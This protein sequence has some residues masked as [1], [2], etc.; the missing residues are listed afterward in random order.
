MIFLLI[1]L[2]A[3]PPETL[4][5]SIGNGGVYSAVPIEDVTGDGIPDIIAALY[6]S[7]PEPTLYAI[8][9]ADGAVIWNS[10]DCKGIW[11]NEALS[12]VPDCNNDGYQDVFL[13][14]P[15]GY[16]PPGRCAILVNGFTGEVI[17]FWSAYQHAP[18]SAGWGYTTDFMNDF[19]GDEITELLAGFGTSSPDNKGC[20]ACLDGATGDTLWTAV[21]D[22]AVQDLKSLVDIT[23]DDIEEIAVG[24]GG[25]GYTEHTLAVLD[26]FSGDFLW[27]IDAGGDVHSVSLCNREDTTPY[28]LASTWDTTVG[29]YHIGHAEAVWTQS[30]S[31]GWWL[32]VKG[33]PDLTE[34]GIGEVLLAADDIGM[35]CYSGV[36][37]SILWTYPSG[38]NTWS[39]DWLEEVILSGVSEVCAV[40]GA[41]NGYRV[42]VVDSDGNL[43]WDE[44]F[45]ERIYDVSSCPS[46]DDNPSWDVLVCL[47]DQTSV[48]SHLWALST[49]LET[50]CHES[51]TL[52]TGRIIRVNPVNSLL[53]L[54]T[55]AEGAWNC[56]I[57]DIAGRKIWEG[58]L[59]G[60]SQT[61]NISNWASGCYLII[62]ERGDIKLTDRITVLSD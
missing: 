54:N 24:I 7:D 4:W 57:F 38:D 13:S 1:F 6:Y 8:S 27:Q 19:T 20:V 49:S 34:D 53:V 56:S 50:S 47:Q 39:I 15:G 46:L 18:V 14:T 43:L 3:S 62:A 23:G 48:P 11:G 2:I 41:L 31:S 28:V 30:E 32:D 60:D 36:D 21:C 51:S 59:S 12:I 16:T 10:S 17:W 52:E 29:A 42:S 45:G 58:S 37:G 40:G 35:R 9:G 22:D 61:L 44:T 33:G 26:G 25:N 5:S 55:P